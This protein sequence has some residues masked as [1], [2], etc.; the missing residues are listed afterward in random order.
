MGAWTYN[1]THTGP[2]PLALLAAGTGWHLNVLTVAGAVGLF[3]LGLDRLMKC[4]VKYDHSFAITHL[5]AHGDH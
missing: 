4:G 3:H 1:L 5:G 2:L